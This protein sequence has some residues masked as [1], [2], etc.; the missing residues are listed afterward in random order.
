MPSKLVKQKQYKVLRH[1]EVP[2]EHFVADHPKD[3]SDLVAKNIR[4]HDDNEELDSEGVP[5]INH[6]NFSAFDNIREV[7]EEN[8]SSQDYGNQSK[9]MGSFMNQFHNPR[10]SSSSDHPRRG[11]RLHSS[12]CDS[13]SHTSLNNNDSNSNLIGNFTQK[14]PSNNPYRKTLVSGPKC[15][16]S[17][18]DGI[19]HNVQETKFIS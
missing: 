2:K 12:S 7:N 19:I 13:K 8:L 10:S 15:I 16:R 6:A 18:T 11:L 9:G 3:F 17:P 5:M 1:N 4:Q 14:E